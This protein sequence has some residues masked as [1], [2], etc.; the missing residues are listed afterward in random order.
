[1]T[2][3]LTI[4]NTPTFLAGG[5]EMGERIRA[6]DWAKTPLGPVEQWPQS[7]RS[8]VSILLPSKAQIVLFWGSQLVTLYNDAYRPVFGAKHPDVL[9]LPAHQA[10]SEIWLSGLK[11]LFEGVLATGEAY[12]ASNRLF[13]L[14]RHGF[15]EET[16]FDVSYDPVRDES[17]KVGGIFCIV[18]ETTGRVLGER[19]LKALRELSARSAGMK[20]AEEACQAAAGTIAENADDVPFALLY[21]LDDDGRR[22]RLA[23]ASGPVPEGPWPFRE[24]ME[25]GHAVEVALPE[26]PHKAVVL[27]MIRP[28]QAQLAGFVVA[29]VSPRLAFDDEYRGFLDLLA[30]HVATAVANAR[31]YEEE[32]RR[33][34]ALAELDRAKTAFFSQRQ[35]RV[36][37]AADADARA[38]SRTCWPGATPTCPPP[39]RASSRSSTATA[40]GCC[41]WSTR[42]STS[43]ASR[44]AGS[45]PPTSRPTW[46]PSP[47]SWPASS[48]RRCERAGLRLVVDCPPL[49]RAGVR[50]PGDVGEDRPQPPLQ[51]LQVHLRGRDRRVRCGRPGHAR[52]AARCGTPARASR[53]RRC[54]ACSSGSTG[55][56]TR[57]AARTRAAA[58]G[59]RWCRS[60]SGCTAGRSPPRATSGR[61]TTFTVAVPLGSAHLPPDRIGES[62]TLASTVTGASPYVEEALRWLPDEDRSADDLGS[63]MPTHYEAL[64]VPALQ[65]EPDRADD[66]PRRPGGRRQRRHAAVH[67][68][69]LAERY[70]VE[71]VADGEAALAAAREQPPGPGPDRRDDAAAGRLRAAAG[72]AGRPAHRGRA[73]HHA[74]GPRRGGEPGRGHGGRGRRLPGQ[75]VQRPR[76][77]GPG[78]GAPADG[79]HAAGDRRDAA[80]SRPPQGRVPGDLGPRAARAAR[81]PG[82]HAGGHEAGGRERGPDRAGPRHHGATGRAARYGWWTTCST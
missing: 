38:R 12:W 35:P 80:R 54:P 19:R 6:F 34:E 29:G 41:G 49:A 75:A 70:R 73:G 60:W 44:R 8:A 79:A 77:A 31:A 52:R 1:M 5:G 39:P 74:V 4:S 9:G 43:P 26:P 81:S 76:A 27:P 56:R 37:H 48:G 15:L 72:A 23:A 30:G 47:P 13:F 51:R 32:R 69:L 68:R 78:G 57:G 21:L 16:F 28:G 58:S 24:V 62:R 65:P 45:R 36:P 63:E 18:S 14:K 66:R 2:R 64:P 55:S 42:C 7:L 20:S 59:W 10:W 25:T 33:A 82:Q 71:A 46:P 11:D 22:T 17:G 53:P 67:R 50:G 40:C 3:R 61:G